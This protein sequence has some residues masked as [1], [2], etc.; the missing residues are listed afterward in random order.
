METEIY[1]SNVS[2]SSSASEETGSSYSE[3]SEN[4]LRMEEVQVGNTCLLLPQ[5]LCE[6]ADTFRE[7]MS[8]DTWVGL[9]E[10]NRQHLKVFI[11]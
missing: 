6:H 5:G 4:S 7:I 8:M 1:W 11:L 2:T 10:Q 9:S 3:D